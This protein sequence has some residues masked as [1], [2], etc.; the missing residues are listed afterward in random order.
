[1]KTAII[2]GSKSGTTEKCALKLK[3]KLGEV[4]LINILEEKVNLQNYDNLIIGS[5]I[6]MGALMKPIKNLLVEETEMLLSKKL[7]IFLCNGFVEKTEEFIKANISEDLVNHATV[8]MSFGGELDVD[9]LKGFDKFV[10]KI[11][12]KNTDIKPKILEENI[13]KFVANFK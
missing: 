13:E 7:G 6:R 9:K 5:P 11:V 10:T 8:I 2:Y 12:S 3:E 1:M 4:D